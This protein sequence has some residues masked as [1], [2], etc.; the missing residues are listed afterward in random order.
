M[1][2]VPVVLLISNTFVS[3]VGAGV[4][5]TARPGDECHAFEFKCSTGNQCIP[6]SYQCD[7]ETDC[8]DRSDEIGCCR[9]F[10]QSI[11][12]CVYMC[13]VQAVGRIYCTYMYT[14]SCAYSVKICV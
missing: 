7:E 8:Q 12:S 5:V 6:A 4:T 13:H 9:L 10:A 11:Y 3:T 1:A 14:K 2:L